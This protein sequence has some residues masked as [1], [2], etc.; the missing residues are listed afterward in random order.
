VRERARVA[1][2][3]TGLTCP[4]QAGFADG[5]GLG[6]CKL[7]CPHLLKSL[8]PA[9]VPGARVWRVANSLLAHARAPPEVPPPGAPPPPVN[10]GYIWR[11]ARLIL[12]F[13]PRG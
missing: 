1:G 13:W 12:G 7:L 5:S 8:W 4:A 11:P 10:V 3:G 2:D 6:V 9:S